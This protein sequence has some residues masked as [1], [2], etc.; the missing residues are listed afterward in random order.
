M[1]NVSTPPSIVPCDHTPRQR[2]TSTHTS[3]LLDSAENGRFPRDHE[4]RPALHLSPFENAGPQRDCRD[5]MK[6]GTCLDIIPMQR[7][8]GRHAPASWERL[9][10]S[11][12]ARAGSLAM[13]RAALQWPAC[14]VLFT[15][16]HDRQGPT[17]T[18]SSSLPMVGVPSTESVGAQ[19]L[20][21]G[22][23]C[24]LSICVG[25]HKASGS[26]P[27]MGLSWTKMPS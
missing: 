7:G 21:C 5:R 8:P 16:E 25:M 9:Y 17:R 14:M 27:S 18:S 26:L 22:R 13:V 1:P 19:G 2:N 23:C 11:R 4:K 20:V 10:R 3:W 6:Q 24:P 15:I 12:G